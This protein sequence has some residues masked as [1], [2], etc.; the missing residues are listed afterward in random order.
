LLVAVLFLYQEYFLL[1]IPV[2]AIPTVRWTSTEPVTATAQSS[3]SWWSRFALSL[4]TDLRRCLEVAR[5][6][7]RGPGEARAS[8]IRFSLCVGVALI[9]GLGLSFAYNNLRFGSFLDSGKLR[10]ELHRVPLFGN[11]VSGFATLLLSPGKSIFLYSPP[12]LLSLAGMVRFRNI[13]RELGLTVITASV[14]LVSFISCILFVGGDWCW[15]PRY[16]APLLPLWALALPFLSGRMRR[17]AV[18]L[19]IGVGLIVQVLALSVENQRFSFQRGLN[20]FFWAEDRWFYFKQ[21]ALFARVPETISL[22]AGLPSTARLFNSVPIPDWSTYSILGPPPRMPRHFAPQW[23]ANFKIYYLPRPWPLWMSWI[24]PAM[25]PINLQAWVCA[26]LGVLGLGL[27][28]I[29]RGFQLSINKR[30]APYIEV[31]KEMAL[32]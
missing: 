7:F 9:A 27:A 24:K 25:R 29:L 18:L 10:P 32:Q 17:D 20:D 28:L 22:N 30:T 8:C 4:Y 14:V 23:M 15:G 2:L 11:P 21:S 3:G 5:A 26:F 12:L 1:L 16:L 13:H 6:A 31:G 19:I